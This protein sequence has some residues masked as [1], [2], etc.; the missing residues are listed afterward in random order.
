M[1]KL[2]ICKLCLFTLLSCKSQREA[3]E[4]PPPANTVDTT[5]T[6]PNL[7]FCSGFEEL[8]W[9]SKWDDFDG[10]PDATN[11]LI[12]NPGPLN[13]AGN[14]VMRLR[15]PPGS[16]VA[17]LIKVFPQSYDKLYAQWYEY[18]EP[19]YDFSAPNHGG[20]L[21]AGHRNFLGQSGIRPTGSDFVY[22]SFE[23]DANNGGRAFFYTYYRGMYM[24][25]SSPNGQCWGDRFPCFVA[26]GYCSNAVHVAQPSKIPPQLKA[27]KWYKIQ[28]MIDMGTPVTNRND[29]DGVINFWIDGIEYGPW[30]NM[31]FRT[32]P[33]LKLTILSLA[34][35]FHDQHSTEGVLIDDITVS[36]KPF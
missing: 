3:I 31:W 12:E 28:T 11:T 4:S 32:T 19:G 30:N 35:F 26:P 15:V 6:N 21:F 9:R 8:N 10:N 24:D 7:V 16:G 18:W 14:H 27:G 25:C 34:T 29:A 13:A 17:D 5:C 23:P 33:D 36:T 20:G 1:K 22:S 2:L